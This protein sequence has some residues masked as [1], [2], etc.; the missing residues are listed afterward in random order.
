M[1]NEMETSPL[2]ESVRPVGLNAG[3]TVPAKRA[4]ETWRAGSAAVVRRVATSV[5]TVLAAISTTRSQLPPC[6]RSAWSVTP[7]RG[8][9]LRS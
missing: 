7:P 3:V 8:T 1:L 5:L 2:A 6:R 4:L 9:A